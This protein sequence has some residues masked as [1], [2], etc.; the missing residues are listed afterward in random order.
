M[1]YVSDGMWGLGVLGLTDV[2][3]YIATDVH[4]VCYEQ[5]V[6]VLNGIC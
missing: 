6:N 5:I 4:Q 1:R 2:R 3:V